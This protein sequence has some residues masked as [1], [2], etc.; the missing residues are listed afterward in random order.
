MTGTYLFID[1]ERISGIDSFSSGVLP[2]CFQILLEILPSG[3]L[4]EAKRFSCLPGDY[5]LTILVM[6]LF[7][8]K[9]SSRSCLDQ[10]DIFLSSLFVKLL[11]LEE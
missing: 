1:F 8:F 9:E 10:S 2:P 3:V 11:L 7:F 5:K 4:G 6:F